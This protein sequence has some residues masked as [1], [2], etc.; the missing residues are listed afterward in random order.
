MCVRDYSNSLGVDCC[1]CARDMCQEKHNAAHQTH[2]R[3]AFV[4]SAEPLNVSYTYSMSG[5][6]WT[7]KFNIVHSG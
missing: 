5:T 6:I 4:C 7:D 2:E 3:V 1:A